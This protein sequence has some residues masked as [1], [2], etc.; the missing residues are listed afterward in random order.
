LAGF[1]ASMLD[2]YLPI[3]IKHGNRVALVNAT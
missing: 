1:K 3:M 2:T